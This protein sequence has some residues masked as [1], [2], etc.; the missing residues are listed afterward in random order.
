MQKYFEVISVRKINLTA[1]AGVPSEGAP[2]FIVGAAVAG[3]GVSGM[4]E[5]SAKDK[6]RRG[7]PLDRSGLLGPCTIGRGGVCCCA[8]TFAV[9]APSGLNAPVASLQC[10]LP[11]GN[12]HAVHT[13]K[14]IR[15]SSATL[16]DA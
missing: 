7:C 4:P 16:G 15:K 10:L 6:W 9:E 3:K 5:S 14:Y 8:G 1:E 12:E 13:F 2:C 11:V